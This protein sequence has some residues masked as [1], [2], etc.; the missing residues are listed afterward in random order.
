MYLFKDYSSLILSCLG[1]EEEEEKSGYTV[2]GEIVSVIS[3]SKYNSC[4]FCRSKV[5]PEDYGVAECT[6]CSALM[7]ISLSV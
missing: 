5:V 4:R 3:V 7:R 6:K 2:K 1:G